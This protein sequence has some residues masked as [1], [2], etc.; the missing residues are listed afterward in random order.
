MNFLLNKNLTLNLYCFQLDRLYLTILELWLVV[1]LFTLGTLTSE[2]HY[3]TASLR[4]LWAAGCIQLPKWLKHL[5][6]EYLVF[7]SSRSLKTKEKYAKKKY[8]VKV[9]IDGPV[10]KKYT[11]WDKLSCLSLYIFLLFWRNERRQI[12]NI[13]HPS[14]LWVFTDAG[15]LWNIS[16]QS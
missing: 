10:L 8:L 15:S 4:A 5:G 11:N 3:T 14:Y 7:V 9:N 13:P 6:A 12:P 2:S 16:K 1:C